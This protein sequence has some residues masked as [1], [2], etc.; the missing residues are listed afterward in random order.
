M[1]ALQNLIEGDL[2][3]IAGVDYKSEF[4]TV[5]VSFVHNTINTI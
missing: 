3:C 5:Y 4:I 2:I 1:E